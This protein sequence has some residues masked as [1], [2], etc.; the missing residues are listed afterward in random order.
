[1]RKAARKVK[2]KDPDTLSWDEAMKSP[3]KEKWLDAAQ[4]ELDALVNHGTWIEV[5]IDEA[6]TKILPGTWVFRRKRSPSG[7]I[8]KYKARYC[9]RGDLQE[10]EFETFAP[11]VQWSSVRLFLVICMILGSWG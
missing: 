3:D 8:K 4:I 10:G 9:C 7:E 5:P 6:T 2:S 11:V 1:M